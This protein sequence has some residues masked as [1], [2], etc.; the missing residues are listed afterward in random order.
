MPLNNQRMHQFVQ[1]R[2]PGGAHLNPTKRSSTPQPNQQ[3]ERSKPR[4]GES[5]H[6]LKARSDARVGN[7][8]AQRLNASK[9]KLTVPNT[10]GKTNRD[11]PQSAGHSATAATATIAKNEPFRS[12]MNMQAPRQV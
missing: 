8:D 10:L 1:N 4:Q 2:E 9:L 5:D 7:Y 12:T 3:R 6:D 11:R